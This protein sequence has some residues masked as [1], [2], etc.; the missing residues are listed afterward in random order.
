VGT[1][2]GGLNTK[3]RGLFGWKLRNHEW[4][5][6]RLLKNDSGGRKKTAT[7]CLG[8]GPR[9]GRF[10]GG[11]G[12]AKSRVPRGRGR[13]PRGRRKTGGIFFHG[14]KKTNF[15]FF[16]FRGP[17]KGPVGFPKT[18]GGFRRGRIKLR[19]LFFF[20][21]YWGVFQK[22]KLSVPGAFGAS[23]GREDPIKKNK[24]NAGTGNLGGRKFGGKKTKKNRNPGE[25]RG[26]GR[27]FI[28]ADGGNRYKPDISLFPG[29]FSAGSYF[30]G[31][32]LM[33][34]T[35]GPLGGGGG[36]PGGGGPLEKNQK[37]RKFTGGKKG[38]PFTFTSRG[39]PFQTN[40]L[41][42]GGR[43]SLGKGQ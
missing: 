14:K 39:R 35:K 31:W 7:A 27:A 43:F 5:T 13:A 22:P 2:S 16:H 25:K 41:Q 3:K 18:P 30:A 19:G 11:G 28:R 38:N 6:I 34:K 40:I 32:A 33:E 15:F 24:L 26:G 37:K 12:K 21:L 20:P 29:G 23:T 8:G 9:G 36:H 10:V 4:F 42:G 17:P 1:S